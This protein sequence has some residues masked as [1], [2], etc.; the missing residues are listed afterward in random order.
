MLAGL[1]SWA[2]SIKRDTIALYFATRDP[3]TP[4]Y[5]RALAGFV[6][7]Y[8][9]SPIDLIPD[10]IPVLGYVD[11]LLLLP[12]GIWVALKLI[13]AAVME[14]SRARAAVVADRPVSRFA[15]FAIVAVWI[16]VAALLG[17]WAY[18]VL[19]P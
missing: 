15:A 13:P 3:R 5:A 8:A 18:S 17:W 19:R 16:G 6:V 9:L 12:L 7:G 14:E 11:D 1:S 2:R 4:W 10:F